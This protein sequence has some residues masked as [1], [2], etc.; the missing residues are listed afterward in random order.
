MLLISIW[1]HAQPS[2]TTLRQC[3]LCQWL[4]VPTTCSASVSKQPVPISDSGAACANPVH[5]LRALTPL[6]SSIT[7]QI[8]HSI[9]RSPLIISYFTNAADIFLA[10]NLDRK[11]WCPIQVY[12]TGKHSMIQA[13][14]MK[15]SVRKL[16]LQLSESGCFSNTSHIDCCL[17]FL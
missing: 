2:S 6:T 14:M 8:S 3:C 13:K 12:Y 4:S 7:F 10:V 17:I 1:C 16:E 5:C 11:W 15:T 9:V